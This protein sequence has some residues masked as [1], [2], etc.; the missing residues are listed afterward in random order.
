MKTNARNQVEASDECTA[1]DSNRENI[2]QHSRLSRERG[3]GDDKAVPAIVHE[4]LR[5]RGRP[6]DAPSRAF[7][8]LRFSDSSF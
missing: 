8:E 4:V 6:L 3:N 5:S 2:F 7:M 1:S